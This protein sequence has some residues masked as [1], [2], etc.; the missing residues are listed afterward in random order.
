MEIDTADAA[1]T[2]T[3]MKLTWKQA[4]KL[5]TWNLT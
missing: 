2:E 4:W 1:D 3:G 5:T